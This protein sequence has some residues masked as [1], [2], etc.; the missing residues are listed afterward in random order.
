MDLHLYRKIFDHI[1]SPVIISYSKKLI[2]CNRSFMAL[3]KLDGLEDI[4]N[5]AMLEALVSEILKE[6]TDH[7]FKS[8]LDFQGN[9]LLLEVALSTLSESEDI[10]LME[11]KVVEDQSL[12]EE[13]TF[14]SGHDRELF[15][16]APDAIVILDGDG[17]IVDVNEAF[18]TLF[19]YTRLETIGRQIDPLL[20]AD[21]QVQEAKA[22]FNRVL[23]QERVEVNLKRHTKDRRLLDVHVIAYPVIIDKRITGNYVIYQD[24][25]EAKKTEKLLHEKEEFLEQLFNRSLFPTAILDDQ[26]VVLDINAKFEELFGYSKSECIGK[27]INDLVISEGYENEANQFKKVILENRTMMAKTKRRHKDGSLLDV[28]TVGSPVVIGGKVKGFFAMYRDIRIEEEALK[29]FKM[30]INTDP[31]T[32]LYNRKFIYEAI[33]ERLAQNEA[34]ALEFNK[35]ALIYVDLDQFKVVNDTFG[36]ETGDLLLV[37]VA[38]RFKQTVADKAHIARIGGDEFLFLVDQASRLEMETIRDQLR[39]VLSD[40][41]EISGHYFST[42]ASLGISFYPDHGTTTDELISA[43]DQSMYREKNRKKALD[44]SI[45]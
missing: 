45:K 19:G 8:I 7:Q 38:D 32:R 9:T 12:Y 41:C 26:E 18:V 13:I 36:H 34:G 43:A 5:N 11:F 1:M 16:N 21:S 30:L 17:K 44:Q 33:E 37:A 35:F 20:V 22:L 28:E 6:G 24:I 3:L 29:N 2:E 4:Q 14:I 39:N 10:H 27:H 23:N 31:L 42:V 40:P 25:T 15:N